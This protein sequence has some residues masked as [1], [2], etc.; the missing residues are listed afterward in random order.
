MVAVPGDE[1]GEAVLDR[2]PGLPAEIA[3]RRATGNSVGGRAPQRSAPVR[4]NIEIDDTFLAA[5]MAATGLKTKRKVIE[6]G[7][8]LLTR[9]GR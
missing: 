5:A 1:A 6:A 8:R 2:G 4:T 9:R 7:L 3:P